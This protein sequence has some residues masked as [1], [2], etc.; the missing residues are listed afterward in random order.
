MN[1]YE[2]AIAY[3]YSVGVITGL[4]AGIILSVVVWNL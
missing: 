1:D 2:N 4:F 3:Y